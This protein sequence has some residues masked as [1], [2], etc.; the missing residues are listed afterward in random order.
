M[1]ILFK[2]KNAQNIV[3]QY[4]V[5]FFYFKIKLHLIPQHLQRRMIYNCSSIEQS[6]NQRQ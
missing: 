3:Y 5:H 4:F 2:N 6:D 1:N